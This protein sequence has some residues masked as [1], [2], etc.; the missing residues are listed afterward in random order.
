L[1]DDLG[2]SLTQVA[3][4]LDL[5]QRGKSAGP[6]GEK[7]HAQ[8][9]ATM[10][11]QVVKSVDEIIWAINPRNDNVRYLIDYLSQFAVEF[12]HAAE[13]RCRV[14]L[15]EQFPEHPVSPE[16]RHNLFL[17]LKETLNNIARHAQA[18]EVRL[19]VTATGARVEITVED[20]GRGFDHA[21]DNSRSDG[22]RNMRQRMD[23]IGGQFHL[24]SKPGQGTRVTFGYAWPGEG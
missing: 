22:L 11:R 24:E 17:V 16:V 18:G 9:C 7:S 2:G 6:D 10:V 21:P 14:D 5:G 3:L 19:R 23:E 15:P 4:L 8:R 1:H 20:N 13:I 12:L